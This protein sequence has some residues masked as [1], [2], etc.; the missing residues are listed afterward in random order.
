MHLFFYSFILFIYSFISSLSHILTPLLFIACAFTHPCP[1]P[2]ASS[3]L[4]SSAGHVYLSWCRKGSSGVMGR[5]ADGGSFCQFSHMLSPFYQLSSSESLHGPKIGSTWEIQPLLSV[6]MLSALPGAA[7]P[8]YAGSG[9]VW[10]ESACAVGDV[11]KED[12]GGG[13]CGGRCRG[14]YVRREV[15]GILCV[16]RD[17][18]GVMYGG[19]DG[20]VCMKGD[21]EGPCT[22]ELSSHHFVP[23]FGFFCLSWMRGL[24]WSSCCAFPRDINE[25][26]PHLRSWVI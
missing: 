20:E 23:L 7:G 5:A 14:R 24:D 12:A 3:D 6:L 16:W 22:G 9:G 21:G 13:M 25:A 19:R 26:L 8:A 17:A 15:Q 18:E 1:G 2:Q 10:M 4:D 11:R